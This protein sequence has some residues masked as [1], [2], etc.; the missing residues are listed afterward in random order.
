MV[1]TEF[2]QM[3]KKSFSEVTDKVGCDEHKE[4]RQLKVTANFMKTG[5]K[6]LH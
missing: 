4:I 1:V 3:V 6:A 5:E 2:K